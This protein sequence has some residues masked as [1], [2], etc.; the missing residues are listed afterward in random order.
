MKLSEG[1]KEQTAPS[2]LGA[3][4]RGAS[5]WFGLLSRREMCPGGTSIHTARTGGELQTQVMAFKV[6]ECRAG[7]RVES[8][9]WTGRDVRGERIWRGYHIIASKL[10]L[11]S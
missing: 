1:T 6:V 8:G 4:L 7:W 10:Y 5:H 3:G 9:E 2:V 11:I